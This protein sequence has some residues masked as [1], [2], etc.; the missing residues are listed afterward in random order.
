MLSDINAPYLQSLMR[1]I[2]TQSKVTIATW[3]ITY[4]GKHLL[5]IYEKQCANDMRPRKAL[6]AAKNYLEGTAKLNEA[7]LLIKDC[8]QAARDA[9]G[10]PVAQA[11][12]RAIDASA[13]A[14][15]NLPASL[16]IA[17][18]GSL[19]LAYHELGTDEKWEALE[20]HCAKEC[21]KMEAALR[22]SSVLNEPNPAK[23]TRHC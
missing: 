1:L 17:L 13:S 20:K 6:A 22:K 11:I 5:P 18:Y 3:C 21:A 9:E 16:G 12:A 10:N 2:E 14:I 7:K 4:A 8:R 23:I 19:G 15:H